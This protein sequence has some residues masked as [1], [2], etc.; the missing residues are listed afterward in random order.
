M[1]V[2]PSAARDPPKLVS[3]VTVHR[4]SFSTCPY[5][6]GVPSWLRD[7]PEKKRIKCLFS[8]SLSPSL[9]IFT[10]H[11]LS[12][13][14]RNKSEAVDLRKKGEK[15]PKNPPTTFL[16]FYLSLTKKTY[17]ARGFSAVRCRPV[18]LILFSIQ[19]YSRNNEQS[20]TL[21]SPKLAFQWSS[22]MTS[23]TGIGD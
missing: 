9:R 15:S 10:I 23:L 17:Q 1:S 13:H 18:A 12:W 7:S 4:L 21:P 8:S 6:S 3:F 2:R 5:L 22:M 20:R 14:Q 11:L 16:Y 19:I